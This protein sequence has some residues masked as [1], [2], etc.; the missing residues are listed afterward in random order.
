M[1]IKEFFKKNKSIFLVFLLFLIIISIMQFRVKEI[2]GFDGWLHIKMADIIKEDGFIKEFPYT[3][4]SILAENYADL[5]LLFR[6]LLIPFTYLGLIYGAKIASILFSALCFTFFYWY[7][8]KNNINYPLF[9]T[10]LYAISSIDLMYR[11]LLPRAMPLAILSLIL[12]FYFIDK[13][14]Y[15]SL[16]I[17][18]LLFT[19]LYH[20][21][22]FQLFVIVVY[23][24]IDSMIYKKADL[25]LL[26]Y[27]FIGILLALIINPYFPNNTNLLYTQIFKVNLIGNLYNA[28]WKPWRVKELFK[29]NY[30]LFSL[31]IIA[32]FTTLKKMKIDKK[33]LFFLILSLIF[34]IAMLKTRRMHEYFAPFT[35]LFTAFSLDDYMARFKEKKTLRYIF[36]ILVI[37]IAIFSLIKLDT[38]IKNNH[39][40]P[41]Y[42]EG[43]E[44]LK[45]NIPRNSRVFINGYI[46]NYLFFYNPDLQYTHGIDLTYSYLYDADKFKSY[47]AVLQGKDIGYN[48]I[49]EDYNA[50]YA[51][52]GKVKQDI[53]LFDYIVKYKDDFELLYEDESVGILKVKKQH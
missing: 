36:T 19:W 12:T 48:I 8:K 30:L 5:Q 26:L 38:Y 50:D 4:E 21:F 17:T 9:W 33:S 16:L 44:W 31:F 6:V 23:F 45:D 32:L 18:S 53:K 28:E 37:I 51:V 22:I 14:M 15:K 7:L 39:F 25:R 49:K 13:K 47:M 42:R 52:V 24:I 1:K 11:F 10:L 46:F 40:L 20:G 35:I 34:L 29:F 3:T 27:P 41:W 2:I 43:G